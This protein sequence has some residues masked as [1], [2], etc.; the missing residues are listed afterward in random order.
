MMFQRI[1]ELR[2]DRPGKVAG[3][4]AAEI[5]IVRHR[6]FN[7]IFVQRKLGVGEQDRK[8]RPGE[9]LLAAAAL[10]ELHV[11]GELFDGAVEQP[12]RFQGLDQALELANE[13][14]TRQE[15]MSP[16]PGVVPPMGASAKE[17]S[18]PARKIR[19]RAPE[20]EAGMRASVAVSA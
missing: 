10:G 11:V 8:F 14:R 1:G 6:R 20:N 16:V 2:A 4:L 5:A 9:R 18:R 7:E 3:E 19:L 15:G 12:A 17:P 13:S